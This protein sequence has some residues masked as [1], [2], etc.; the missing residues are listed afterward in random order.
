MNT[1]WFKFRKYGIVMPVSWEGW[2]L[3]VVFAALF[4]GEF[5]FID[6]RSHSASD[7]LTAFFFPNGLSLLLL[8]LAIVLKTA[9]KESAA[10]IQIPVPNII[11]SPAPVG[12]DFKKSVPFEAFQNIDFRIADIM[13]AERVIGSDK[14]LKLKVRI[15]VE[16]RQIVAGIG[17]SYEPEKLIGTQIAIVANLEPK[18]LMGLE[19]RG[20]LL[21]ANDGSGPALLRPERN[22]PSGTQVR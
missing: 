16:E 14:L 22:V 8:L 18:M 11:A 9:G 1:I 21:A 17:K 6:N 5:I 20:M 15:G 7:T 3:S 2:L 19:S 10:E 4:I 12:D 13:S